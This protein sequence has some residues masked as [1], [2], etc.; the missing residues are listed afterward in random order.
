[1]PSSIFCIYQRAI[2]AF[3]PNIF[4]VGKVLSLYHIFWQNRLSTFYGTIIID[5]FVITEPKFKKGRNKHAVEILLFISNTYVILL[6]DV[7]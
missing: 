2:I 6:R 3:L 5:G 7:V 4:I 1:P